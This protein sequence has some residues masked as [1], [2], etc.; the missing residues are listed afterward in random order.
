M[1]FALLIKVYKT[2]IGATYFLLLITD[3][4]QL[5]NESKCPLLELNKTLF[6]VLGGSIRKTVN[7]AH[8]CIQCVK[9]P[10]PR[11]LVRAA[12]YKFYIGAFCLF[13]RLITVLPN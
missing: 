10:L 9:P 4:E 7:I 1:R 6:A 2:A 3:G 12:P 11:A 5:L 8:E 13:I